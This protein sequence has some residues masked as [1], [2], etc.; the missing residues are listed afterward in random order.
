MVP[1]RKYYFTYQIFYPNADTL[2]HKISPLKTLDIELV[3]IFLNI[4]FHLFKDF[5]HLFSVVL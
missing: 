5:R 4:K 3:K 2:E 1:L